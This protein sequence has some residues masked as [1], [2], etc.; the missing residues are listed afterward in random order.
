MPG[1]AHAVGQAR[2]VDHVGHVLKAPA[3]LAHQPGARA[4][5]PDLAAGHR[6]CAQ[7]VLEPDDAKRVG[8]PIVQGTRQQEQRNARHA[9]RRALH[10]RQHHGQAGIGVG[11]EPLVAPQAVAFAIG[12]G[13]GAR[14]GGRHIAAGAL[15]GHEHRALQQLVK[16]LRGQPRQVLGHQRGRSELAQRAGERIGHRQRAAQAEL[17]LHEQVGQRVLGGRGHGRGPVQHTAPVRQRRQPVA[18]E[19]HALQLHIGRVLQHRL[20]VQAG[21]GA[22]LQ[23][24][25]VVVGGVGQAVQHAAGQRPQLLQVGLQVLQQVGRQVQRQEPGQVGVAVVQV[26]AVLVG[27]RVLGHGDGQVGRRVGGHGGSGCVRSSSIGTDL[28]CRPP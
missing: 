10:P 14:G 7:L 16:V 13:H 28:P 24:G 2:V 1:R 18:A 22:V 6:A 9:G 5:Q 26:H 4:L 3:G 17:G 20:L 21:A 11:A 27:H 25:R 15:L 8:R 19:G 12:L 23:R